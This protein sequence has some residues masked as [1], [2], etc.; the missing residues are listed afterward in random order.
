[1]DWDGNCIILA[2]SEQATAV[3][4][5]MISSFMRMRHVDEYGT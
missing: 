5:Y 3:F 4:W 2:R 1:L